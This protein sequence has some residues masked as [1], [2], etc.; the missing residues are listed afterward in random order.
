MITLNL[1]PVRTAPRVTLCTPCV[2]SHIVAGYEPQ[3]RIVFCGYAFPLRE[4]PFPV[5]ECTDFRTERPVSMEV[6]PLDE[7]LPRCGNTR[8]QRRGHLTETRCPQLEMR[9]VSALEN[10]QLDAQEFLRILPKILHQQPHVSRKTGHVVVE[11]RIAEHLPQRAL[12][13]IELGRCIAHVR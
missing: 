6:A 1:R 8:E 3:D 4:V 13:G 12:I 7:T 9:K 10:P 11:R 2:F 5:K